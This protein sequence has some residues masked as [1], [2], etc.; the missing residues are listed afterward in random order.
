MTIIIIGPPGSGKTTQGL[1]LSKKLNLSY[2]GTGNLVRLGL[3]DNKYK[4]YKNTVD[5]G[6]LLPDD[7]V[8]EI[9]EDHLEKLD[10]HKGFILEGYPRTIKQAKLLD[11]FL[12]ED[13][14][15]V[16]FVFYFNISNSMLKE[17]INKRII[18]DEINRVDDD[19]E[20]INNRMDVYLKE[21]LPVREYYKEKNILFDINAE[22]E[23]NVI[24][25]NITEKIN[26]L[27]S[28]YAK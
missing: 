27:Q 13:N 16:N 21:S 9:V 24:L 1:L 14:L 6:N 12:I 7:V 11:K 5:N 25:N 26:R 4:A 18:E 22:K 2:I 17:R 8:F 15:K 10:I 19:P 3:K 20:V 23:I 28:V